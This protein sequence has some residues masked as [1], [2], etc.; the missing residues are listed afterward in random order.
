MIINKIKEHSINNPDVVAYSIDGNKITYKE[1]YERIS[2][3]GEY[4][5]REGNSKVIVYGHKEID[6]F[7]SILSCIYAKRTYIPLDISIPTERIKSIINQSNSSLILTNY[8]LDIDNINILNLNELEQYKN[9]D[10]ISNNNDI[11]YIIFTSGS[12]GTPKGVP[13]TYNNLNNFIKWLTNIDYIKG[14]KN[15]L[16]QANFSFDLSVCD[17]Y[18]SLY[19]GS[20]L[21]ILNKT[22]Y[23]DMD[24][25]YKTVKN[26]NIDFMVCTPTFIRMCMLEPLF[27]SEKL[28]NLKAILF[29]GEVLE[30]SLVKKIYSRFN[31]INIINAYGPTEATC[32]VCATK[33]TKDNLNDLVLPVGDIL[34]PSTKIEIIDDE[35]VLSGESVFNGY[36]NLESDSYYKKDNISYFNTHDL[37]Y[38]ENNKL[39]CKGRSDSQIKLNGYRI[40]LQEIENVIE[41]LEYIDDSVVLAHTLNNKVQ[42]IKAF[43]TLNKEIDIKEI[44]NELEKKLPSYMIPKIIKILDKMPVNNNGKN[45]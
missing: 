7:I 29:C 3:Y 24:Y 20:T 37:G 1:L 40:E 6:M 34:N 19:N 27:N 25:I 30:P 36:L 33:I 15:V 41:E 18:Y 42:Y 8:K 17:I 5:K 22:N 13:V 2:I 10:I 45:R 12:T 11:C 39:Y 38:I 35:I 9:N 26:N 14:Y 28:P 44:Y 43:I 16:N 31:D 32:F 4:L 21:N 23:M